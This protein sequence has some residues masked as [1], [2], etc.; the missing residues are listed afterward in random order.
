[1]NEIITKIQEILDNTTNNGLLKV[2]LKDNKTIIIETCDYYTQIL[3]LDTILK[4]QDLIEEKY[5][6]TK[7]DF[8]C[9][10]QC[11]KI[12][13]KIN[14][15]SIRKRYDRIAKSKSYRSLYYRKSIGDILNVE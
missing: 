10:N 12:E 2:T 4:I 14:R 8:H 13:I 11:L 15:H 5:E 3:D 7:F 9:G 1:M 6:I